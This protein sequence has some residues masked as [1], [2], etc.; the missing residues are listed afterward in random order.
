MKTHFLTFICFLF[1]FTGKIAAQADLLGAVQYLENGEINKAEKIFWAN[2]EQEKAMEYLGDIASFKKDWDTAISRY[3][4]LVVKYPETADYHFKLGGAMG[5]KALN[6]S[7]FSAAFLLG[8]IKKHLIQAARLDSMHAPSR[9]AL[10]ELHM[11]LPAILGGDE[12]LA[13]KYQ[14]E[15]TAINAVDAWLAK[16]FIY[17]EKEKKREAGIS[18]SKALKIA[19][20]QPQL[21][22]RNYLNYELAEMAV[23]YRLQPEFSLQLLKTYIENY[24]YKDLKSPK[25]AYL[26]M[27]EV[28]LYQKN[29]EKALENVN[30]ALAVEPGFEEAADLKKRL[31]DMI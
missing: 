12:E 3:K 6:G 5:L 17:A 21:L 19:A 9:R 16:A 31:L 23:E 13:A 28:Q 22:D 7:K 25:W 27:A 4:E 11:Q 15:L 26:K 24:G 30:K 14:R 29:N 8:D 1:V 2:R 10:V 20:E 18:I